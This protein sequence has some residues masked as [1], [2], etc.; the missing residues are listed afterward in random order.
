MKIR[1]GFVTNS[2]SS[3]YIIAFKGIK[4]EEK[5]L[6][7]SDSIKN[8]IELIEKFIFQE[9]T[10]FK[11][12]EEYDKYFLD[13]HSYKDIDTIEKILDD[14]E[15]LSEKYKECINKIEQ[16]YYIID[17]CVDYQNE[18]KYDLIR[19]MNDGKNFI[20]LRRE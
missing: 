14:D 13:Q 17:M 11:T 15:Y 6:I 9:S 19:Y 18:S 2:S 7:Q 3:S 8:Y 16:G 5:D 4:Q 10:T 12:K 20:I 1:T